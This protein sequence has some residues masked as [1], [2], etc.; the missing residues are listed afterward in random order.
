MTGINYVTDGKGRKVPVMIDLKPHGATGEDFRDGLV[1]ESRR[2]EKSIPYAWYRA[3]RVKRI[4]P[5]P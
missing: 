1:S 3:A 5:R 4:R 2:K